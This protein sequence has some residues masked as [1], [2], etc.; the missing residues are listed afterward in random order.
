MIFEK[1]LIASP[2]FN[3]LC[4]AGK[5]QVFADDGVR[6]SWLNSSGFD[7]KPSVA[8]GTSWST[9]LNSLNSSMALAE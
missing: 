2:A 8:P 1:K 5:A 9:F 7:S 6:L 4:V 3:F